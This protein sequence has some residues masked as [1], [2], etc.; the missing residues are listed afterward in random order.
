M[1]GVQLADATR[2]NV[3]LTVNE[4]EKLELRCHLR[5]RVHFPIGERPCKAETVAVVV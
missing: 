2:E 3:L 4:R 1:H 5:H